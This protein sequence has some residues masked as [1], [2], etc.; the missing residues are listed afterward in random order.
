MRVGIRRW[1]AYGPPGVRLQQLHFVRTSMRG[2]GR[3][4]E[5]CRQ[6]L[7]LRSSCDGDHG[8]F[9]VPYEPLVSAKARHA[10]IYGCATSD[11]LQGL[12][13]AASEWPLVPPT[14]HYFPRGYI[15]EP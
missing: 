14:T 9:L 12:M 3:R 4:Q 1:E 7:N 11:T 6:Y 8:L 13:S 5:F 15:L 10:M 2:R